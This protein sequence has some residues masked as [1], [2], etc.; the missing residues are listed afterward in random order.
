MTTTPV[1]LP[2][3]RTIEW[4]SDRVDLDSLGEPDVR[5]G[6]TDVPAEGYRLRVGADG[7]VTIDAAD[8]AGAFYGRATLAQLIATAVDGAVSTVTV[9]DWPDR[10]VRGVMLDI[11]RDKVPTMATLRELVARLASWKINQLQLYT[12]HTFAYAG[13]EQVWAEASPITPDE[14]RDLDAFCAD[15]HVELVPNQN[16]LG[17]MERWLRHPRYRPLALAPEGFEF[18]GRHRLASTLDPTN[19]EAM[20]LVRDLYAQLLPSVTSGRVNIGLDEPWELPGDRYGDYLAWVQQLAAAPELAGRELL[21]W[22]DIVAGHPDSVGEL[23][24]AVTVCEWGYDAGHPFDERA[25]TLAAAGRRF[26]LCPG[27]SSWLTIV[28]RTTNMQVNITEACDAAMA[29]GADGL[30]LTDWGD[31]GHLQYLPISEPGFA[32]F[33]AQAWC[34]D[35][36]RALDLAAA[37]DAHVWGDAATN[38][39]AAVLALGDVHRSCQAQFPNLAL[40]VLHLYYPESRLRPGSGRWPTADD[41]HAIEAILD[42]TLAAIDRAHPARADG[43]LVLDELR[44]AIA[45]VRLAC[46]DGRGRLGGDGT[47]ASVPADERARWA[48]RLADVI[49]E[50]RRLWLARNRPGG[51]DDSTAWLERLQHAYRTG[52]VVPHMS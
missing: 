43:P 51:L 3:P 30:L 25:A 4:G 2:L 9:V 23:P 47:L 52:E 6:R 8:E 44:N 18:F 10:A 42:D 38:L 19:P 36:N 49:E 40:N 33:A 39:G 5:V 21:M 26:W 1:L 35:A 17:H 14:L 24:A 37:L 50:H 48:D 20:A 12:E 11:A 41:F 13:H 29:H 7:A 28:G 32:W 34:R 16:G 27:T 45:I 22:G 31:N 15:Q 46:V